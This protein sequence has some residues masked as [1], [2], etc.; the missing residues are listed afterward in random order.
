MTTLSPKDNLNIEIN[1]VP[2]GST[3]ILE[4]GFYYQKIEIDVPNI[5]IEGRG[6]VVI[7]YDDYANKIH[8]DGKEYVTF[9]TYTVAVCADNVTIKNVTIEN[10]AKDP[11]N[12]GQEVALTVYGNNFL[13]ENTTLRSTQDTLFC[14]PLPDDLVVRYMGFLKDKLRYHQGQQTHIF[15]NCTI[16]GSVDFIFGCGNTLFDNCKIISVFDGREEAFVVA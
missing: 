5:T 13:C 3:I 10:S 16:E 6:N 7:S 12:K 2:Q 11:V 8:E 15:K 9:R 4:E 1:K 14:G